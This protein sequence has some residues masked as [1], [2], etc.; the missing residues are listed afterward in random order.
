MCDEPYDEIV[1]VCE[2]GMRLFV[3]GECGS[4]GYAPCACDQT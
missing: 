4:C 1:V 2:D 3:R